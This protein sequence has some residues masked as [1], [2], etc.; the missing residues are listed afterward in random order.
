MVHDLRFIREHLAAGRVHV[1][2]KPIH[3]AE[4]GL[5]VAES[6]DAREVGDAFP[7]TIQQRLVDAEV[8][9]VAMQFRNAAMAIR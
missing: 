4:G 1:D 2:L 5:M 9:Q 8:V 6:F 7:G 3:V